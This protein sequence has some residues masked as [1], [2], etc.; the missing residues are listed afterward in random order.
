MWVA[1]GEELVPFGILEEVC[2]V[3]GL[4]DKPVAGVEERRIYLLRLCR[5]QMPHIPLSRFAHHVRGGSSSHRGR[6]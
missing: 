5:R 4:F 1:E 2:L 3:A 6:H